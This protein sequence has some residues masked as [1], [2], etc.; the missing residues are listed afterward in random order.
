MCCYACPGEDEY[1]NFFV[2]IAA[3]AVQPTFFIYSNADCEY[4]IFGVKN[5]GRS[6]AIR[7]S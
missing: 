5:S 3:W 7:D 2:C 1:T 4:F 6:E